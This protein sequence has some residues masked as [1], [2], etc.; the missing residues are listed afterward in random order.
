MDHFL[1]KVCFSVVII[2]TSAIIRGGKIAGQSLDAIPHVYG[3]M[4]M[5]SIDISLIFIPLN[6]IT[7]KLSF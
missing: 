5:V 6:F 3:I 4:Y 2:I 1:F 7:H